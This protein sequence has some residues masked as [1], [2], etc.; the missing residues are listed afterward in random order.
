MLL[1]QAIQL[2]L[3]SRRCSS[4]TKIQYER[5]LNFFYEYSKQTFPF[6]LDVDSI[7]IFILNDFVEYLKKKPKYMNHPFL[8]ES[9]EKLSMSSVRSYCND[10]VTF[11]NWLYYEN[12]INTKVTAEFNLPETG[13]NDIQFLTSDDVSN[14][15]Q[16][17]N[18]DTKIGC[19]NLIIF[20]ALLDCGLRVSEV[21]NL[22]ISDIDFEL[23]VM[24]IA[25]RYHSLKRMVP[26]SALFH[27]YCLKYIKKYRGSFND[28]YVFHGING[29]VLTGESI[30]AIFKRIQKKDGLSHVCAR[31]LRHTFALSFLYHGGSVSLCSKIMSLSEPYIIQKY[32]SVL[33]TVDLKN[34]YW[35]D[36]LVCYCFTIEK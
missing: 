27:S 22:K 24:Y 9:D 36:P 30:K 18:E 17:F 21:C 13:S 33:N 19:R 5:S 20:S 2:F 11:V 25:D 12:I 32:V 14:V 8:K 10:I 28:E 4:D 1:R 7:S 34:I 16:F 23:G 35:I 31:T 26:L 15:I 29:N 3:D 6:E